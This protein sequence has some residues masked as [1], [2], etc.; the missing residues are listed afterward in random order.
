[1][2]A[3]QESLEELIDAVAQAELVAIDTEFVR[4]STYYPQLCLLQAAT[5]GFAACVDCLAPIELHPL[6]ERLASPECVWVLHSARQD[7]EVI[8]HYAR[9]RPARLIDTQI[10]S[11]LIGRA[12]QVGLQELLAGTLGIEL[13]K[14]FTRTD[15]SRRPL[16]EG[17]LRYALDDVVHLLP[18]WERLEQSLAELG[19][20]E[21]LREDC[22]RLLEE[23]VGY[24]PLVIWTRLKGV[25]MLDGD[26]QAAAMSLVAWREGTAQR[27]D[28]PRRWI[29]SDELLQRIAVRKPSAPAQLS[30][31]AE[32]PKRLAARSGE[33]ILAALAARNRPEIEA[34]LARAGQQGRPDKQAFKALQSSVRK[35]AAQLGIES[36]VLATRRDLSALLT[37]RPPAHLEKGWRAAQ[38]AQLA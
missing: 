12:P 2:I 7:L 28:R 18:L 33:E 30:A 14:D 31:V 15:W 20:L 9:V 24:D 36:E 10:A 32:M 6:F 13:G 8:E 16:P 38:I 17:A 35:R 1:M 19:R 37:G 23:A 3:E 22:G 26:T 29:M 5:R 21:W 25:Q 27:L 11:A 34:L 4:E